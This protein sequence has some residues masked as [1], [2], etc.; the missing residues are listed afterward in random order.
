MR[1]T[2]GE[3]LVPEEAVWVG[4]QPWREG[5]DGYSFGSQPSRRLRHEAH[6]AQLQASKQAGTSTEDAGEHKV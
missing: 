3:H 6:V 2:A 4:D 5:V 1:M